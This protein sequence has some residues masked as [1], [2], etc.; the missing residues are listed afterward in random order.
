MDLQVSSTKVA[1]N[2]SV[3]VPRKWLMKKMMD[4]GD[5][6]NE[7]DLGQGHGVRSALGSP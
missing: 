6:A 1:R 2:V 5:E 7:V 3:W 4:L